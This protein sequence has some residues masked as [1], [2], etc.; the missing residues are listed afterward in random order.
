MFCEKAIPQTRCAIDGFSVTFRSPHF[1]YTVVLHSKCKCES[2]LQFSPL[3]IN[4][5]VAEPKLR[6]NPVI[7][8]SPPISEYAKK[9]KP[10]VKQRYLEKIGINPVPIEN[11]TFKPDYL[12][13]VQSTDRSFYL[14]L[15]YRGA[16]VQGCKGA[17]VRG[18][19]GARVRG[20]EGARVQGCKGT[21]VQGYMGTRLHGCN[22]ARE[23]G[24]EGTS[25]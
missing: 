4:N 19:E 20:C 14:L 5:S 8:S 2:N 10:K 18:C 15:V 6:G 13:P 7:H 23:Q 25:V 1:V 21:R 3:I 9:V 11:E 22:F 12:P 16:R 17:R 24:C